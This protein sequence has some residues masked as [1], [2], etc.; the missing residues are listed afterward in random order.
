MP[1]T[2]TQHDAQ[3]NHGADPSMCPTI[4]GGVYGHRTQTA[5]SDT[6][7]MKKRK[8]IV[9][10]R[11]LGSCSPTLKEEVRA[12]AIALRFNPVGPPRA[13]RCQKQHMKSARNS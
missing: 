3:K 12:A 4:I 7:T 6:N 8:I 11:Q 2:A 13:S 10:A 5:V 9:R 1:S